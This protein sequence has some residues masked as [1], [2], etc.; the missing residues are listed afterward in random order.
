[1]QLI[2]GAEP[3]PEAGSSKGRKRSSKAPATNK[4]DFN[5]EYAKSNRSKCCGCEVTILKGEVRIS[6]MDYE[7]EK[8][9]QFGG[10]PRW[11]HTEC[12]AKL[13]TDL[14][15]YD[16]GTN[17]PGFKTLGQEDKDKV[18]SL[19]PKMK[20]A[21]V[22]TAAKKPKIEPEDAQEE[23]ELKAQTKSFFSIRD[24]LSVLSR[25]LLVEL[26]E[27]NGQTPPTADSDVS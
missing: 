4:K 25:G 20:D 9:L 26:L 17:I 6:K 1:M 21:D 12:F 13:R 18:K 14:E 16:A 22:P 15:Y 2:G 8:A 11:Y 3:A 7:G 5:V 10:I 23:K 24:K 27:A 19:L